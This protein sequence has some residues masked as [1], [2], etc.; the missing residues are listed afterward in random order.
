MTD[1]MIGK[2][3]RIRGQRGRFTVHKNDGQTVTVYGGTKGRGMWR[4]FP[5]D[6]VGDVDHEAT[7]RKENAR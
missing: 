3:V 7:R 5:L 1:D 2:V 6:R 4:S